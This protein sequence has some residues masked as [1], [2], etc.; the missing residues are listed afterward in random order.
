MVVGGERGDVLA[1]EAI[2][3]AACLYPRLMEFWQAGRQVLAL[4][5]IEIGGTG[6]HLAEALLPE[7]RDTVFLFVRLIC[8]AADKD[9]QAALR[10][11]D[12]SCAEA[13]AVDA[14]VDDI[15]V[16]EVVVEAACFEL[17]VG[18]LMLYVE[19]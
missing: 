13:Q 10:P 16:H 1:V 17:R 15:A 14:L 19:A 12:V 18:V 4:A 6:V 3:I 5:E 8:R 9:G 7:Q 2:A 11:V